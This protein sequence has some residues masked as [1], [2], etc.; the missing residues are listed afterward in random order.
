MFEGMGRRDEGVRNGGPRRNHAMPMPPPGPGQ[1][2]PPVAVQVEYPPSIPTDSNFLANLR[3]ETN[4]G[5]FALPT[6]GARYFV[7]KSYSEDDVHRSIKV[8]EWEG[9]EGD[10]S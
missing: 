6:K 9:D 1:G 8:R 5:E 10:G 3:K 4:P 7:I 2:G